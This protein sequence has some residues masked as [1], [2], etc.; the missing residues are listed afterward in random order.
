MALFS[1]QA[2]SSFGENTNRENGE[3]CPR[4]GAPHN[5]TREFNGLEIFLFGFARKSLKSPNSAKGIQGNASL[6]AWISLD[7]LAVNSL[8]G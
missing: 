8:V 1:A 4:D 7:F 5:L 2:N 6:F 3:S